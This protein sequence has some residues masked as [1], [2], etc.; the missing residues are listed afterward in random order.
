MYGTRT[1]LFMDVVD[2]AVAATQFTAYMAVLNL[3]TSYTSAWQGFALARWGYP[4]TLR[5]DAVFGLLGLVVLPWLKLRARQPDSA[6]RT[7]ADAGGWQPVA[8]E[9]CD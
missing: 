7:S 6:V 5:L 2:P 9:E 4:T 8:A 1:A 3:T